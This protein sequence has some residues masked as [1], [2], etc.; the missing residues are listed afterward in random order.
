MV[1]GGYTTA[2][3]QDLIYN[4]SDVS[5]PIYKNPYQGFTIKVKS[6]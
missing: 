4:K 1:L 5:K 2:A 6:K 3:L